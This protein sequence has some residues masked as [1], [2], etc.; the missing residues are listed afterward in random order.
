MNCTCS[1]SRIRIG[2]TF[3]VA[4]EILTDGEPV[5]LTGRDLHVE[6]IDQR[7]KTVKVNW[8]IDNENDTVIRFTYEG[9]A[10]KN[11]TTGTYTMVVYENKGKTQQTLFDEDVFSLVP[12]TSMQNV[13][14][15]DF[16]HPTI[17]LSGGG[18][19]VGGRD[20]VGIKSI[21]F[22][23]SS[24]DADIYRVLLSDNSYYDISAR[25][26][27]Y[28]TGL[29][30]KYQVQAGTAYSMNFSDGNRYEFFI[31]CGPPGPQG[32][33][34]EQGEPGVN[35]KTPVRG[36][37]YWTEED[38][39]EIVRSANNAL[40]RKI[41]TKTSQLENDSKFVSDEDFVHTDEN[42]TTAEKN[43]LAGIAEGAQ[44][45]FVKSVEDYSNTAIPANYNKFVSQGGITLKMGANGLLGLMVNTGG[46]VGSSGSGTRQF[47]TGQAVHNAIIGL[48]ALANPAFVGVPTA[49]TAPKGTNSQQI[50][51]TAFVVSAILDAVSGQS[52]FQ[53]AVNAGTDISELES[54]KKGWNWVV[55]T[56]GT[57][58][59]ETCEAGDMI[60]CISN[61]AT[62]FAET[63]FVVVQ[64]NID[65][66][67][68]V[69]K[70]AY[71][72][73]V[74]QGYT[75]TVGEWLASLKGEQGIQ[76]IQGEQGVQGPQGPQ[77]IQGVQ[78]E[79]GDT[80]TI[81]L[82]L[83]ANGNLVMTTD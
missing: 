42:Y 6:L 51:T 16:A 36:V 78:G 61:K 41:P 18:L 33:K 17:E 38:K 50:A 13:A 25:R 2:T 32:E 26:G 31:P 81:T 83:D 43:K 22:L 62:S 11:A 66:S 72:L 58:A 46:T 1:I 59:G 48:A 30:V 35:G 79:K 44:P 23:E 64:K 34:G 12:K 47:V 67:S 69:G 20:G 56:A 73:A 77:G 24:T 4:R 68:L 76:G 40:E 82:S 80:P 60:F 21:D 27:S 29:N 3:Q 9:A 28:C 45:N 19:L 70:S 55:K 15:P 5:S 52:S 74:E 65:A 37:D 8:Y 14:D 49:P 71:E 57:Y 54:Y 39:T 7:G 53:G 63:D 10:Q 75:G